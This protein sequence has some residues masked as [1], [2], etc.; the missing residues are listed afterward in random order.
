MSVPATF[1]FHDYETWGAS[2]KKD[3][4][5]QFAGIRTDMDFNIIGEP[6]VEYCQLAPDYLPHPEACLITGITPQTAMRKGL[7]EAEFVA[8]IHHEFSQANTCVV[9]YNSVRF[10][11]EV[12]RY[13]FYRNFY[14]P[15]AREWQN[16]NSR[17]DIIDMVRACYALRPEGI[18]WP[19]HE[20]GKPSFRLEDLTKANGLQHEKAHDALSDVYATI[21]MAK[22]I[23]QQQPKLF[24]FLFQHRQKKAVA[25]LVD[26]YY[27][28]PL[29]HVSSKI[30]AL[31]GCTTWVAPIAY[32]PTNS[33]AV[34]V[35]NLQSDIAP[36]FSLT[37]TEIAQRLY[38]KTS[39]LADGEQRIGLKLL[40][41]NK[42]PVVAPA[43]T[44]LPE[45]AERLGINREQCL[46]N[47]QLIKQHPELRD[48]LVEVFK[49]DA[50]LPADSNPDYMLYQSF[51]SSGDKQKCEIV[52]QTPPEQLA[53]LALSFDDPKYQQLLFRYR[54]RNWPQTL[55][56]DE[57]AKWRTYC[58][59]RHQ[60]GEDSPNLTSDELLITLENLAMQRQQNDRDMAILKAVYE[61]V[62]QL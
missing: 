29:V 56:A 18:E 1:F 16:G 7:I 37:A 39:D 61:Y 46:A 58:Q 35:I 2:P 31:Q 49:Q 38:T 44:L 8:K 15:Y 6:V 23:K 24:E 36:L 5:A 59:R 54:A 20:D 50:D 55:T 47:L 27:I 34:I 4:P 62:S 14:D 53:H 10:D 22:L 25:N 43:K 9:G 60:F 17:W 33:N 41:L 45:N 19:I 40:H 28:T 32:H 11:D 42:C 26:V 13:S 48:K 30:S 51:P 3:R 12:S 52:R 57:L 21:A